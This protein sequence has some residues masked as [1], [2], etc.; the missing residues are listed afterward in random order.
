ML[1]LMKSLTQSF[2]GKLIAM[3]IIVGM[4]VWGADRVVNQIRTGLGSNLI[5]AGDQAVDLTTLDHRAEILLKNLNAQSKEPVSKEDLAARGML[6]QMFNVLKSRTVNLGFADKIGVIPSTQAMLAELKKVDA[7]RN[8]LTGELDLSTYQ[9]VLAENRFSQQEYEEQVKGDLALETLNSA[10][11]AGL[12]VPALLNDI[13]TRYLAE[14]RDVAWFLLDATKVPKPAP[15]TDEEIKAFYDENLEA[16]KRPERRAIDML[17]ISADDFI[18]QVEVTEQEIATIYEASKSERFSEPEQRTWT[19]LTFDSRDAARDAFAQLAGGGDP[20]TLEGVANRESRTA[21]EDEIDD[22]LLR[23]AMFGPGKQ[24]G[25]LFGPKDMGDGKWLVARLVSIQPGA[26]FPIETVSGQIRSELAHERATQLLYEKLDTLDRDIGAGYDLTK[27]AADIGVPV[28][29]FEPVDNNGYAADGLPMTGLQA[30]DAAFKQAFDIPVGETSNQ[31]EGTDATYVTAPRKIIAASTPEFDEV[32]DDVRQALIMRNEGQA[33]DAMV[34]E[35]Q[36]RIEGGKS[37]LEA[38]AAAAGADIQT[39]PEPITRV[40]ADK[41][42]L[43]NSAIASIFSGKP[44]SVFTFPNR[45]GD[46]YMIVQLKQVNDPSDSDIE[47]VSAMASTSLN[48]SLDS[49]MSAALEQE[50]EKAVKLRVNTAA[51]NAYKAS[52]SSDQ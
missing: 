7:F 44:G 51:Y 20:A 38:E 28:M 1:A 47:A 6:D 33:V 27:I 37:T 23:D 2:L 30:A 14:S 31:F 11:S 29:S 48:S 52:L 34:K 22:Q 18:S 40:N 19:E 26:V 15:P 42:G 5:A 8:P 10:A 16:L 17:K 3:F 43:P 46:H 39:S 24:S 9:R 13:Q 4:A 49:D 32:K 50:V 35:M 12:I 36:A 45:T 41:S 21:K 25:A